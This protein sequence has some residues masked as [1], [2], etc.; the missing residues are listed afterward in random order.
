MNGGKTEARQIHSW[1][2]K[3]RHTWG[4]TEEL[5]VGILDASCFLNL[6]IKG[7]GLA[8]G[9]IWV[10]NQKNLM[11]VWLPLSFICRLRFEDVSIKWKLPRSL[12]RYY[13]KVARRIRENEIRAR[14]G[15]LKI[16]H[17]ELDCW[18]YYRLKYQGLS[19]TWD[20]LS[21][22]LKAWWM[23][24]FLRVTIGDEVLKKPW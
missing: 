24:A 20:S 6:S 1:G 12:P 15:I 11:I 18:F 19:S 7:Y 13:P 9:G 2:Y 4:L 3:K 10:K 22:H 16:G 23:P 5:A 14:A 8:G 21:S 17:I